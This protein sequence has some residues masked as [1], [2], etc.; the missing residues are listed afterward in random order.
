MTRMYV[1]GYTASSGGT[2]EGITVFEGSG[3]SGWRAMQV[4]QA[5][6]PTF[7]AVTEGALHAASETV[8]GRVVSYTISAGSLVAASVAASGGTAP[9]HLVLDPASGALVVA[10]Y[11]A[12]TFGVLA[13]DASD[14]ARVT[15][16]LPLP[17]GRGP[18]LDRQDGPHA[19]NV[20]PTPEGTVLVSDLGSDRIYEVRVDP[21]TLEPSFI[22]SSALPSGS[23][24]RHFAWLGDKLLITGELDGRLH[25]LSRTESGSFGVDYSVAAYDARL[26][27]ASDEVLLSHV[28][29][30]D[31][32]VYAAV[33]GRDTITVFAPGADG[34]L[35]VTAEVP[36]GGHWPRHFAIEGGRLYVAN[37]LSHTVAVLPIGADGVPGAPELQIELGSPSCVVFA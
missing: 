19:H 4:V 34:R 12:G 32:Y 1:G 36:A 5:D 27:F 29:V 25:V 18:V 6:D 30:S 3:D 35:A 14:P 21:V 13:A 11:T 10:N 33:R 16:V 7:L 26:S 24:P 37:Q 31:G 17:I 22:G 15:R 8:E 2:G 20:M 9:C 28:A 23:G